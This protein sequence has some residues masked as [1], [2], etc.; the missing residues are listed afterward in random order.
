MNVM[1]TLQAV[2]AAA[3][4]ARGKGLEKAEITAWF[5]EGGDLRVEVGCGGKRVRVRLSPAFLVGG[6]GVRKLKKEL[7]KA[8]LV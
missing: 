2:Q 8:W 6:R 4:W 7:E 3:G 5:D 1:N